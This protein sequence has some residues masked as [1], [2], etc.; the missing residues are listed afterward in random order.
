MYVSFPRHWK[1]T[2]ARFNK[3]FRK[4]NSYNII[5]LVEHRQVIYVKMCKQIHRYPPRHVST[6]AST[7]RNAAGYFAARTCFLRF[8]V[9]LRIKPQQIRTY[10]LLSSFLYSLLFFDREYSYHLTN[11]YM[12]LSVVRMKFRKII[13]MQLIHN[14]CY[15]ST[16]EPVSDEEDEL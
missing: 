11:I 12:Q 3:T 8:Y 13:T 1:D 16:S 5:K 14:N 9:R 10:Q 4:F 7:R 6:W 15:Y 2:L